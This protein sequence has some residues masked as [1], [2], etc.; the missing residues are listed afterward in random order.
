MMDN[1]QPIQFIAEAVTVEFDREPALIK[2]PGCPD[3]FIWR[4]ETFHITAVESEW[5]DYGRHPPLP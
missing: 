4:E 5:H 1:L 2:K 3:R